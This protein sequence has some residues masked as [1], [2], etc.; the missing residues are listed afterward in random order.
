MKVGAYTPASNSG[1][2]PIESSAYRLKNRSSDML[3]SIAWCEEWP[4]ARAIYGPLA[5][6]VAIGLPRNA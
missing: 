6:T 1:C 5:P 2:D 3:P 4:E